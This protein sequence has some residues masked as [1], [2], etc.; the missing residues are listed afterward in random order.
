MRSLLLISGLL[1]FFASGSGQDFE[2]TLWPDGVINSGDS[3]EQERREY[4]DIMLISNVQNPGIAVYLPAQRQ[5]TGQAVLICPGGGY[6]V[7]AYDWEGI[8]IARWFNSRGIAAIVLRYRLP[9]SRSLLVRHEAP[10]QDAQRAL[11]LIRFNAEHWN[12]DKNRIGV[13]GFSAGGHLA[14][15]LGTRYDHTTIGPV[16]AIDKVSARPDFMILVYPVVTFRENF[17]H[18]GSRDALLG[19]NRYEELIDF[20]SNELH[21]SPETPRTFLVHSGDDKVVPVENSLYFY[22]SLINHGVPAEM[23]IYPE[24]GHGYSLAVGKG[25]LQTWT[26]RLND[27][28]QNLDHRKNETNQR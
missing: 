23:H 19:E 28:L 9:V 7:L 4:S 22:Q 6:N 1:T 18:N 14:S 5:A 2:V 20:Y 26:D 27:W 13:I 16:D 12:I 15:T 11:R 3:D 21:V 8:D 10:L 24:G 25:Y 17:A